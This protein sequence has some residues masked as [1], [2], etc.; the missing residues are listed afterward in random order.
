MTSGRAIAYH[1]VDEARGGWDLVRVSSATRGPAVQDL[2]PIDALPLTVLVPESGRRPIVVY[3]SQAALR[4]AIV[5]REA[6]SFLDEAWDSAGVYL[7]LWP[8]A[9]LSDGRLPVYVGEAAQGLRKRIAQH[10]AGKEGWHRAVLVARDTKYGFNSAQVGWL[11]GRLWILALAADRVRPT[12]KAQPRDE[13]LPDYDRAVLETVVVPVLRV[14]RVLGY[15]LSPP[16]EDLKAPSKTHY[17]KT[18]KDLLAAGMLK[19]GEAL[20]FTYPGHPASA[21]VLADGGLELNGVR[22]ASPSAAAAQVRGGATNG[23]EY[24]ARQDE[25]GNP[26]ALAVLRAQLG[27]PAVPG[28]DEEQP[29]QA[30]GQLEAES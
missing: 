24:W 1:A 17:G 4:L 20:I 16:D 14:L 5:E 13:T 23:W 27:Q 11:E 9:D 26:I 12:N 19:V 2:G 15:P 6:V 10:V 8:T 21:T 28:K 7:L 22:Y 18:L 30:A 29:A 25:H 3:D